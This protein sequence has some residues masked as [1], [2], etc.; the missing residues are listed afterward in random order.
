MIRDAELKDLKRIAELTQN[1]HGKFLEKYGV[2]IS[3]S[4]LDDTITAYIKAK[5]CIVV[6]RDDDVVGVVGW[7]VSPH[8]ANY[9]CILFQENLWA[10]SSPNVM[11]APILLRA[12]ESKAEEA[13]ATVLIMGTLSGQRDKRLEEVYDKL[14]YK[15]VDSHYAKLIGRE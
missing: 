6:D 4:D 8:P 10:L 12:I 5:Q 2:L 1:V 3:P 7:N 11:D 9:K 15:H 14:G 13:K